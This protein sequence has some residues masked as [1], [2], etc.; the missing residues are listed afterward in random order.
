MRHRVEDRKG[1]TKN[2]VREPTL[3]SRGEAM[4]LTGRSFLAI[5][6]AG[7][8]FVSVIGVVS[9]GRQHVKQGDTLCW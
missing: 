5:R 4:D 8:S 1:R 3:A 9:S 6:F 7:G 2:M